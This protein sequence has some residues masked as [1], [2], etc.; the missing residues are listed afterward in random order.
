MK[1]IPAKRW[2]L[3]LLPLL[4]L[5]ALTFQL[6]S[7]QPRRELPH[8]AYIWQHRWTP[9]VTAALGHNSDVI[10]AWRWLGAELH[11]GRGFG[12]GPQAL[13]RVRRVCRRRSSLL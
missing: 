9:A 12:A 5:P 1:P 6:R 8:D 3:P 10:R 13:R 7:K 2:L 4:V 11:T